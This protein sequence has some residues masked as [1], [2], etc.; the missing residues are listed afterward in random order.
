MERALANAPD[1][2][3]RAA[4]RALLRVA[5]RKEA[6]TADDVVGQCR[7]DGV[8]KPHHPNAWGGL[9][10]MAKNQ[11]IMRDT[12]QFV[13]SKRANQNATRIPMYVS[14]VCGTGSESDD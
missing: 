12:G 1:L 10:R 6:F 3:A 2:W 14:L 4:L 9:Y 11:G 13:R 5:K 8:G 7:L